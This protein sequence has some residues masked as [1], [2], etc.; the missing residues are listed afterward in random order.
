MN[1]RSMCPLS[2]SLDIFG[3]KWPLLI[4]CDVSMFGKTT[5]K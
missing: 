4:L 3:D 5:F 1:Y 2:R